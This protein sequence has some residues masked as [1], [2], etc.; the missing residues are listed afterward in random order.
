MYQLLTP[1][2]P[3]CSVVVFLC[4]G[5]HPRRVVP[6]RGSRQASPQTTLQANSFSTAT[7]GLLAGVNVDLPFDNALL[8]TIS[9]AIPDQLIF[10]GVLKAKGL[11]GAM[12]AVEWGYRIP[13]LLPGLILFPV[14]VGPFTTVILSRIWEIIL[15]VG[16]A[17]VV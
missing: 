3:L 5:W 7:N 11:T 1:T 13:Q 17:S 14:A 8:I 6:P 12:G 2:K 16:S 4:G 9:P 15:E 10:P